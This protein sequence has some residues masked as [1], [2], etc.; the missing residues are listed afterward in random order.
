M[1]DLSQAIRDNDQR[2]VSKMAEQIAVSDRLRGRKFLLRTANQREEVWRKSIKE[3]GELE[4]IPILNQAYRSAVD[5]L[6]IKAAR[7]GYEVELQRTIAPECSPEEI[8]ALVEQCNLMLQVF[9]RVHALHQVGARGGDDFVD[10]DASF[11]LCAK[12][13]ELLYSLGRRD[14]GLKYQKLARQS[15]GRRVDC[16]QIAYDTGRVTLD[17]LLQAQ[18]DRAQTQIALARFD[19]TAAKELAPLRFGN[20]GQPRR[21]RM[22]RNKEIRNRITSIRHHTLDP[23]LDASQK[24]F[25]IFG[26]GRRC[27]EESGAE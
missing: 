18:I 11:L 17:L 16:L 13:A 19:L 14:D 12:L 7:L 22:R 10:A 9:R 24:Q 3:L 8:A 20:R 27:R 25:W 6:R 2:G 23:S 1:R 21:Q 15:A 5:L 26:L 4:H